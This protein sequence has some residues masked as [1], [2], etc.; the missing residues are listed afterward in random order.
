MFFSQGHVYPVDRHNVLAIM[1]IC[2]CWASSRFSFV[3]CT[4]RVDQSTVLMIGAPVQTFL[5]TVSVGLE[6]KKTEDLFCVAWS[7]EISYCSLPKWPVPSWLMKNIL[8]EDSFIRFEKRLEPRSASGLHKCKNGPDELDY[9]GKSR[10]TVDNSILREELSGI[11]LAWLCNYWCC[12]ILLV[13]FDSNWIFRFCKFQVYQAAL[14]KIA[15]SVQGKATQKRNI[16]L[17]WFSF[18]VI[19]FHSK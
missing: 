3:F 15:I 14:L 1:C 4:F 17:I 5:A 7:Y 10:N 6:I 16:P 2:W 19:R 13:E 9:V 8:R 18:L 11:I 12:L